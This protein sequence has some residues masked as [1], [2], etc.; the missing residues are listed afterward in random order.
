M[1]DVL[2]LLRKRSVTES[3]QSITSLKLNPFLLRLNHHEPQEL[4][5][6]EEKQT[7]K[8]SGLKI[9]S[10]A[11]PASSDLRIAVAQFL[12]FLVVSKY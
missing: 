10:Q 9:T 3:N 11:V 8:K 12:I 4:V 1:L 2:T 5:N 6:N 7:M